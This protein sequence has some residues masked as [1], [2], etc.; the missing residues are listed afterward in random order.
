MAREVTPFLPTNVEVA[1]MIASGPN[2]PTGPTG[3]TGA[4][5][6][7]GPTGP[8]G[9]TG[10]TGPTGVTGA[11]GATGPTGVTGTAGAT[12][13]TGV[14]G[15]TG[16]TGPTGVTGATGATGPT[17]VTGA[18]GP[19]GITGGAWTTDTAG[20]NTQNLA[21][22]L[23]MAGAG[24][25]YEFE[26]NV[27]VNGAGLTFTFEFNTVTTNLEHAYTGAS[28]DVSTGIFTAIQGGAQNGEIDSGL[29]TG[30]VLQ[31]LRGRI[32]Q[33]SGFNRVLT[34]NIYDATGTNARNSFNL[35]IRWNV[36]TT[37]TAFRIHCSGATGIGTGSVLRTRTTG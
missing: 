10:P 3:P 32:Q 8:T 21:S 26:A 13:P 7:T 6:P 33:I 16:A 35:Q 18:T 17:G 2:G 1:A 25:D 19:T 31:I 29:A 14:T 30:T 24:Q 5:G 9:V 23:T 12:G 36:T 27:N 15:A 34:C 22:T 11:T 20:G 28:G 37:I 4:T